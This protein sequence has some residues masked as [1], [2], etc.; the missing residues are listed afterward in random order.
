MSGFATAKQGNGGGHRPFDGAADANKKKRRNR[1]PKKKGVGGESQS[2]VGKQQKRPA[3]NSR[4][5]HNEPGPPQKQR[6]MGDRKK[7]AVAKATIPAA[8]LSTQKG[9]FNPN[10][11]TSSTTIAALGTSRFDS[12]AVCQPLKDAISGV[13]GYETMTKCQELSIP[14]SVRGF[15][16]LVKAKTGTGKTLAFLIPAI[17]M[18]QTTLTPPE[19][20]GKT[21]VLIISPTRELASQI[22]AEAKQ[23]ISYLKITL[24]CCYGGTNVNSD[25]R[26]FKQNAFPDILVGTP[27]RLNDHLQNHGLAQALSGNGLRCL[28]FDEADQ[29][30]EMGFRPEITKMLSML[31]PK[32]TRQTLLFSATMPGDILTMS[33]FALRD[34]FKHVDCVGKEDQGTHARVPQFVTVYPFGSDFENLLHAVQEGMQVPDY[35]IIVFFVTA[36]L[37][38]LNAEL[39]NLLGIPV[40]EIH[41]RKSQSARTKVSDKFRAQ[42]NLVMFTSDVTAR[43]MDYP[44][45][46][47]VIQCGLPSDKAQYIHRLG[48]TARAG[49]GGCGILLLADFEERF[50]NK[51]SDQPIQRRNGPTPGPEMN[52]LTAMITPAVKRLPE[53]TCSMGY[54][55]WLGY[56]NSNMKTMK[57]NQ[58]MLVE[59]ANVY[60]TKCLALPEP[61]SLQ[62]KTVGKMGLRGVSGLR[63]EG[64]NGVPRSEN[65]GAGRGGNA[66]H[67]GNSG[68]GGNPGRGGNA[69]RGMQ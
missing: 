63:V 8:G 20:H 14:V 31:P 57:W 4:F 51:C 46:S 18:I 48:R 65:F 13:L 45:V 23:L 49:K 61:P 40:L 64:R 55:A 37:T 53:K 24:Q 6:A 35:K 1:R 32:E 58:N 52:A 9:V 54:Q 43:G 41:S 34:D 28:I 30:L 56:Y 15:D 11:R 33:K 50:L 5:A 26:K 21:S 44:D 16:V 25:L 60:A 69:K 10:S 39:F 7:A 66:G 17:N 68:R 12:L 22:E 38:Q 47:M 29:L 2:E 59:H 27:G 67:G 36:R 3:D 19:R 62:A 42:H